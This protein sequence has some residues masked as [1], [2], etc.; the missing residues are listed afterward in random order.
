MTVDTNLATKNLAGGKTTQQFIE[1]TDR[2]YTL[3][4]CQ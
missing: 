2:F 3:F 1:G 4:S